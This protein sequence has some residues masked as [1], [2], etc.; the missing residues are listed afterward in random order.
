MFE[1]IVGLIFIAIIIYN[2]A[3]SLYQLWR[4]KDEDDQ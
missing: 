4:K 2:F 1:N 3:Y